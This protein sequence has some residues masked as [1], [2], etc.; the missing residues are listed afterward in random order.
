MTWGRTIT[1]FLI[2]RFSVCPPDAPAM[3][4]RW[5]FLFKQEATRSGPRLDHKEVLMS[6]V[7]ASAAFEYGAAP[8]G[9]EAPARRIARVPGLTADATPTGMRR[10]S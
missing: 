4:Y 8:A 3:E 10:L 2:I 9:S 6:M 1:I 7:R 5:V